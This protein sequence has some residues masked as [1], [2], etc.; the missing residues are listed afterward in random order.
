[1]YSC[2]CDRLWC[3]TPIGHGCDSPGPLTELSLIERVSP[4]GPASDDTDDLFAPE[5]EFSLT[6]FF[7]SAL[8]S[9]SL[10]VCCSADNSFSLMTESEL[11]LT[12][13]DDDISLQPGLGQVFDDG[14]RRPGI[15]PGHIYSE[16]LDT[17]SSSSL[18]LE[19]A[20][21][22]DVLKYID[23]PEYIEFPDSLDS[24]LGV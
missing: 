1:M 3:S 16:L 6:E 22:D 23:C 2:V 5:S 20:T 7:A 12:S 4:R 11:S 15:W 9:T 13:L 8:C 14:L 19:A 24:S 18:Y 21:S 17:S 10:M